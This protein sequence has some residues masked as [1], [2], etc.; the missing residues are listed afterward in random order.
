M[1]VCV[2]NGNDGTCGTSVATQV[3]AST[4]PA[5]VGVQGTKQVSAPLLA[6]TAR[7]VGIVNGRSYGRRR[8]PRVLAGLVTVPAGDALRDVR[9]RLQRR[10]RRRCF[11]FSGPRA[12]FVRSRRCSPARFFSV[13]AAQSFS[14]LL[15]SR[16]PRGRYVYAV[17][18]IDGAGHATRLV[19]GTSLVGFTVR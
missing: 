17:E 16:L 15:P 6:E 1:T 3:G 19:A 11:N 13:G 14:Y 9:I 12:A 2:H 4:G 18:A 7:V 5:Q 10:Y 8:A